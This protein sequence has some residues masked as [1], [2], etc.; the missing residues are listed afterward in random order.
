MARLTPT[1][2]FIETI[3]NALEMKEAVSE[4]IDNSIDAGATKV[5]ISTR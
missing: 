2:D 5:S 4:L 1:S 3:E